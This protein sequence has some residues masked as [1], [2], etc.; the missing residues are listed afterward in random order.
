MIPALAKLKVPFEC[1]IAGEGNDRDMLKNMVESYKLNGKVRFTGFVSDPESLWNNCDIFCFPI[2]WQEPFGLVGLEAMAHGIPTVAFDRGGV[3]EWLTDTQNGLAVPE[4]G[5][6]ERAF[7]RL[8]ENPRLLQN[9]GENGKKIAEEKF[10]ERCFL[11]KF[12][13]LLQEGSK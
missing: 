13:I 1:T 12:T 5:D 6:L 9:M 11:E 4:N 10:S 3:R 8:A 2:R 7:T